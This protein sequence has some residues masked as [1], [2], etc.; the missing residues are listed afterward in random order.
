VPSWPRHL[1]ELPCEVELSW[2]QS[3]VPSARSFRP[4]GVGPAGTGRNGADGA[5]AT[6]IRLLPFVLRRPG[7]MVISGETEIQV[8]LYGRVAV[9]LSLLPPS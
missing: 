6:G 7:C 2:V 9:R 4:P 8:Q 1:V 3:S 5:A